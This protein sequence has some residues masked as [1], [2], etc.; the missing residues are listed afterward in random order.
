MDID[1][2]EYEWVAVFLV[3][4]DTAEAAQLLGDHLAQSYSRRN[5]EEALFLRSEV[6]TLDDPF[7]SGVTEDK[8]DESPRVLYGQEATD[9]EIGW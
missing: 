8:W 2:Q 9:R 4:A 5:P 6:K 1:E 7:W 3:E